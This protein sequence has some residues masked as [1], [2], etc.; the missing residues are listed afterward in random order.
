M[1]TDDEYF[2]SPE[3][4]IATIDQRDAEDL[5]IRLLQRP[6]V[7]KAMALVTYLWRDGM[8]IRGEE[9]EERFSNLLKEYAFHHA[10]KAATRD[11]EY[12]RISRFMVPAHHWFGRDVPGSRWGGDSPDFIY[13]IISL[14]YG[15]QY[16]ILGRKTCETAPAVVYSLMSDNTAAPVIINMLDSLDMAFEADGSFVITADPSAPAGRRNHLQTLPGTAQIWIRD[17]IGDWDTQTAN[18]LR[19]ERIT[20]TT[21]APLTEDECAELAARYIQDGNYYYYYLTQRS[22]LVS[23]PND[24]YAP[25]SSAALGGMA[26]QFT[27][28]GHI[29]LDP[30]EALIITASGKGAQFRNAVLQDQ[31][32][33]TVNY[34]DKVSSL[35]S[36][37]MVADESGL[38]TY[39]ISHDDP[40]I[41]NWLDTN[42]KRYSTF[43]HRWQAF[44]RGVSHE[45]P[46]LTFRKVKFTDLDKELP[47]G[48]RRI[49]AAGRKEQIA[50]RRAG[51]DRRFLDH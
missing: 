12:P 29:E 8:V 14:G 5:A 39:V 49:D 9:E 40:G 3:N 15:P 51:F 20:P 28:G 46:T 11:T 6:E 10:M 24:L 44:E 4:P 16:Q 43:C 37:Q 47:K 2:L 27:S 23:K 7:Q 30:D 48:V 31:Y 17:A 32:V 45:D 26:S 50:R 18:A 35:N 13:R 21:R 41:S 34:W 1:I 38:Y 42:G 36:S 19:V 33:V 25:R 22:H